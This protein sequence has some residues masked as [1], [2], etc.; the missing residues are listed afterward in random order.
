MKSEAVLAQ[1][2]L[3]TCM[4]FAFEP[5]KRIDTRNGIEFFS[6]LQHTLNSND[7]RQI[8]NVLSVPC[9]LL[10]EFRCNQNSCSPD[11]LIEFH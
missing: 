11:A 7:R 6:L 2:E 8:E 3:H 4:A 1:I 10:Y 5:A 9:E